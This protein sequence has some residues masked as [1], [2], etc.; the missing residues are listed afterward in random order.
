MTI[1][2]RHDRDA[3]RISAMEEGREVGYVTY[4]VSDG[5]MN[6]THTVIL[7]EMRGKGIGRILVDRACEFASEEGFETRASCSYAA[8]VLAKK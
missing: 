5:A 6:I 3:A 2:I 4:S 8:S 1:E 7:P